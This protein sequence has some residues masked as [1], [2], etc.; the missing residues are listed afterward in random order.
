MLFIVKLS[1]SP[2]MW[3]M[4]LICVIYVGFVDLYGL[5]PL[6]WSVRLLFC[7]PVEL[8]LSYLGKVV[9]IW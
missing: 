9:V 7:C 2:F 5:Q 8:W 4:Y 6:G 1:V 3:L